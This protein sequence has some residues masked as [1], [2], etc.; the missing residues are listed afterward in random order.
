VWGPSSHHLIIATGNPR[1]YLWTPYQVAVFELSSDTTLSSSPLNTMM[2]TKV[3][4]NARGNKLLLHDKTT[5]V[6]GVPGYEF[7]SMVQSAPSDGNAG[8]I[9]G[10][11]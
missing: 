5:M 7:F 6:L 8:I 4:W 11:S 9:Y 3:K 2:I 10:S 1:F